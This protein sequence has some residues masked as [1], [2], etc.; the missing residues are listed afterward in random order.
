MKSSL[1][2]AIIL[3]LSACSTTQ[4]NSNWILGANKTP[5]DV[6]KKPKKTCK[7]Q[8]GWRGIGLRA[9]YGYIYVCKKNK[10]NTQ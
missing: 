2:L 9:T 10:G 5:M 8:P 6:S 7:L 1:L 3:L 4:Q